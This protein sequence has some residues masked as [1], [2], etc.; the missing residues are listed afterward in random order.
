MAAIQHV[1][2]RGAVYWW[3]RRVPF[4]GGPRSG[5]LIEISLAT[6]GVEAARRTAA[7]MTWA[8]E[9]IRR[10]GRLG[11]IGPEQARRVLAAVARRHGAKLEAVAAL[12]TSVGDPATSE[13]DDILMGWVYR[14][15][16]VRGADAAS[17]ASAEIMRN[18]GLDEE[19]VE[20]VRERVAFALDRGLYPIHRAKLETLLDGEKLPPTEVNL[21]QAQQLYCRG[22]A[23]ALFDTARRWGGARPEDGAVLADEIVLA[24]THWGEGE[25]SVARS[26]PG[27]APGSGL[28]KP[29]TWAASKTKLAGA[30][31]RSVGSAKGEV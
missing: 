15:L 16:A 25:G 20:A 22:L 28:V 17:E 1:C 9:D 7:E 4:R 21:A 23:T 30:I 5:I 18:E 27:T 3:R 29:S 14:L 2:R 31:R 13:R 26:A 10:R 12:E 11:L 24:A 8:S 6:R 19:T